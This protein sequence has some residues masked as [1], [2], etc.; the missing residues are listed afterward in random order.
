M[1]C[2]S[3]AGTG[4]HAVGG[5]QDGWPGAHRLLRVPHTT[6]CQGMVSYNMFLVGLT[7]VNLLEVLT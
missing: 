3:A 6:V 4:D 2:V 1:C 7:I 5:Q